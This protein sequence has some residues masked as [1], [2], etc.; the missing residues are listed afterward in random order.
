MILCPSWDTRCI[1]ITESESTTAEL[2]IVLLF[3]QK[4]GLGLRK[5][6]DAAVLQFAENHSKRVVIIEGNSV[7]V[8]GMW[9]RLRESV[10]LFRDQIRRPLRVLIDISTCP[11]YYALALMAVALGTGVGKTVT[12]FYCEGV[13]D[14]G[15]KTEAEKHE[16][17]TGGEW[18]PVAVPGLFGDWEPFKKRFY[19]ASLGFEGAKTLRAIGK[20]DPD[21]VGVLLPDPGI[22]PD[23]PAKTMHANAELFTQYTVP[24]NSVVRA[25]A[26]DAIAAWKAMGESE[27][28]ERPLEENAYYTCAGTKPHSVALAL[29]AI[30]LGYPTVLYN[31]PDSHKVTRILPAG[32]FWRFELQDLS[33]LG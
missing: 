8:A 27:G 15:A 20:A 28:L 31:L 25:P 17:F 19:L 6:H 12:M 5:K 30:V 29:R 33:S 7:D 10:L 32:K 21:R 3:T 16:I 14:D 23:Y 24:A 11:R 18:R 9:A 4:D 1:S 13:Y 26:G 2:S 22:R